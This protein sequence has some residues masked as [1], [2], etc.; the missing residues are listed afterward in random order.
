ME[1]TGV[2]TSGLWQALALLISACQPSQTP[3][4]VPTTPIPA[5]IAAQATLVPAPTAA[6]AAPQGPR[7]DAPTYAARGPFAVGYKP[8]VIGAGSKHPLEGSLRCG[9]KLC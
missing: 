4:A 1:K 7:P 2:R 8:L 9:Q 5:P 6:Q 3:A